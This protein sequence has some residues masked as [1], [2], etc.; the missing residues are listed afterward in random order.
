M[1]LLTKFLVV[2]SIVWP[3]ILTAGWWSR[4]HDGPGWLTASV[5][6]T[7]GRV[8]HQRPE[9]SFWTAGAPWPVCGRCSGLYLSAPIG[10]IAAIATRR[11]R[12]RMPAIGW[13]IA[14]AIPTAV[15]LGLQ[16]TGLVQ[17]SSLGRAL[18]ALPLG[19]ASAFFVV[20][21]SGT[22]GSTA[23]TGG[24]NGASPRQLH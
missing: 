9:R 14:A 6:L 8:C 15:S 7:A 23:T 12:A 22:T 20:A 10:A 18:L 16:W 21:I 19:F 4:T 11:R 2:A 17:G 24:R 13:L 3:T 5:Y 1:T